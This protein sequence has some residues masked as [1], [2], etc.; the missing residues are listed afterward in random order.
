MCLQR[1]KK[2]LK[3]PFLP[4]SPPATFQPTNKQFVLCSQ[5]QYIITTLLFPRLHHETMMKLVRRHWADV[6]NGSW[7]AN[8]IKA[9]FICLLEEQQV[10]NNVLSK[11]PPSPYWRVK[12]FWKSIY[13]LWNGSAVYP[14]EQS[15]KI[16]MP[17]SSK[18]LLSRPTRIYSFHQHKIKKYWK[19]KRTPHLVFCHLTGIS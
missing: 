2:S 18:L 11:S 13:F 14:Q 7:C 5:Y 15:W 17:F 9:S 6:R 3:W 8:Q 19:I 1:Y 16:C 12:G 10:E 4:P